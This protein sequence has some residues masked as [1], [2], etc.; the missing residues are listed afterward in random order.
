MMPD[1][2]HKPRHVR[3]A[4]EKRE[5]FDLCVSVYQE[6]L[7][8][9]LT[10]VV[11]TNGREVAVATVEMMAGIKKGGL[12][13]FMNRLSVLSYRNS[14]ALGDYLEPYYYLDRSDRR[15]PGKV[16]L[17]RNPVTDEKLVLPVRGIQAPGFDENKP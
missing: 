5:K 6:K 8:A 13:R 9:V 14:L 3:T 16:V 2:S 4:R 1:R 11:F 17:I 15:V 12:S 7:H 10:A